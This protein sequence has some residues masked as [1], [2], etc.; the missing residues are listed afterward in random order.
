MTAAVIS[1]SLVTGDS[2][3]ATL[4]RQAELR[5]GGTESV[6]LSQDG[7]FGEGLAGRLRSAGGC[8]RMAGW[9]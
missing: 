6:V 9:W 2:V 4:A 1:G 5:L 3:R 7:F 8:L